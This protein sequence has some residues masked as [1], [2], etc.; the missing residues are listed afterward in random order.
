VKQSVGRSPGW[1]MDLCGNHAGTKFFPS[2]VTALIRHYDVECA[3]YDHEICT[4]NAKT[5]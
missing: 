2:P 3:N 1:L 4:T 5:S